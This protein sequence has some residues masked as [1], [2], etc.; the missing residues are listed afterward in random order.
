MPMALENDR[1]LDAGF[2]DACKR[3]DP[4]AFHQLFE[5]YKDLVY[6]FALRFSGDPSR[7]SDIK[8]DIFVKL[9]SRI[10][11]FRGDARFETWLYRVVSNACIDD[12]RR[13]KR[14]L[15]WLDSLDF[16]LLQPA[17]QQQNAEREQTAHAVRKAISKLSPVLRVPVLLRYM[18]DLSYEEI[19]EVL[20]IA[21]GTVASRLNRAH[22]L[23]S[24][25]LPHD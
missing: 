8:Q 1:C 16:T 18:E 10:Q 19:G 6:S 24:K 3:G 11:E 17:V 22:K 25:K 12:Q 21:P 4:Q 9:Y 7:A 13:R 20:G 14:F 2:L 15:P 23:L 5:T